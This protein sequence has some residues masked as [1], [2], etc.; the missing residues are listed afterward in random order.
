MAYAT[1]TFAD[2]N[3]L[4][5]AMLTQIQDG[6]DDSHYSNAGA[7]NS[8]FRGKSLGSSVTSTQAGYISAG[9]FTDLFV[10]DYW[11]I[12]STNYRIGAFNY[13]YRCGSTDMTTQNA[14]IVTDGNMYSA[15]MNASNTTE[16][17][18]AGSAM[19]TGDDCTVS[20]V[21]YTGLTN[22]RSTIA[23]AFGSYLLTFYELLTNA[24]T[25]G[26]PSGGAWYACTAELMT[27]EM[28]YGSG[29]F[30][31]VSTGTVVPYNYRVG[32]SQLPLFALAPQY[33]NIRASWWL[34]GVV[35]AS[36]FALVSGAGY[37]SC[38]NASGVSGVRPFFLI[39]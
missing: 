8:I 26:Y 31:P 2:G 18:Y 21:T 29:I 19:Y 6:V 13:W 28:V 36:Y 14:L 39:S 4:T 32:K 5:A 10:G 35:S 16:G 27:A 30:N 37:A 23:S 7:H 20:S 1:Q 25:S 22:A 11:T 38:S 9:T 3:T 33:I 17:G 34:R 24:V 15:P 12:S